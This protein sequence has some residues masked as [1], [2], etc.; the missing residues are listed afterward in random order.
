VHYRALFEELLG[1]PQGRVAP[2][3]Q[4]YSAVEHERIIA[5]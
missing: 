4:R 2:A 3:S 5:R 1:T